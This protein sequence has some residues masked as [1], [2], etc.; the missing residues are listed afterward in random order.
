M[1][2]DL[3]AMLQETCMRPAGRGL[4]AVGDGR[5][6]PLGLQPLPEGQAVLRGPADLGRRHS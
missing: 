4:V 5:L 2:S 1:P 3:T 6:D